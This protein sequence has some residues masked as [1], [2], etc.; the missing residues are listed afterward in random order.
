VAPRVVR[1]LA[2]DGRT[3]LVSSH[4][5]AEVAQAVDSV[6]IMDHGR[7]VAQSSL[8]E[9]TTRGRRMVRVRTPCAQELATAIGR[10]GVRVEHVGPDRL[11]I[12]GTTSERVGMLAAELRIP[13]LESTTEA[14]NLEDVFFQLTDNDSDRAI[15][16]CPDDPTDKNRA[17][18]APHDPA[19][20]WPPGHG[21]WVDSAGHD[22]W[23]QRTWEE[24]GTWPRRPCTRRPASRT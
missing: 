7:L 5:L 1:G 12:T 24:Q 20:P 10:D 19:A 15:G 22:P 17:P 8:E 14:P 16:R 11:E 3:I 18:E 13:I 21:G 6:V 23:G 9:L 4:I 2:E